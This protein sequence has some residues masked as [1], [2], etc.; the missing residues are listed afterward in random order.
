MRLSTS[1]ALAALGLVASAL[2]AAA[3][4]LLVPQQFSTIQKALSAAKPYDTVLVSA[5]AKGGVYSEVLTIGTPHVVLQGVG[6][7]VIDGSKLGVPVDNGSGGTYNTS[8]NGIEIK[9]DHVAVRGMTVQNFGFG[10]DNGGPASAINIGAF[11]VT[12]VNGRLSGGEVSYGDIE[13]SGD[14]LRKNYNGLTIQG[15]TGAD[16]Q[17]GPGNYVAGGYR[18]AGDL[19]TGN[20]DAGAVISAAS[21]LMAGDKIGGNGKDGLDIAGSALTVSGNEIAANAGLGVGITAAYYD[22]AVNDPKNPNPSASAVIGNAIHNNIGGGAGVGGTVT[23]SSNLI[24]ANAGYGV[25]LGGADYSTVSQNLISGTTLTPTAP[26]APTAQSGN[27]DDGTGLYVLSAAYA[28]STLTVTS[29]AIT[30]NAGDGIFLDVVTGATISRNDVSGNAGIGI[31]LSDLSQSADAPNKVTLNR[32]QH[33]AI[34]DARDDTSAASDITY[35]R[36]TYFGDNA[37]TANVWTKNLFGI[38][39]PKGLSK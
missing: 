4:T 31:H 8:P 20:S 18:I 27:D 3:G 2:P 6:G 34:F 12:T 39:D 26:T 35:R 24:S 30:G 13:I 28:G 19:I 1:L 16:P 22:P 10:D 29:N 5:K 14:T 11:V 23:V 36:R 7:P 25:I 32:A 9:A 21:V 37:P 33:N 38:T 17:G 15:Y